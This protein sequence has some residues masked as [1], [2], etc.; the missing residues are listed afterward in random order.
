MIVAEELDFEQIP[1]VL[2]GKMT[3]SSSAAVS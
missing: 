1:R 2:H 3:W